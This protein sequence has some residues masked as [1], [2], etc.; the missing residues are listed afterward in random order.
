L[1]QVHLIRR[2]LEVRVDEE[3]VRLAVDVFDGNLEAIESSGFR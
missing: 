1:Q 2:V 3:R